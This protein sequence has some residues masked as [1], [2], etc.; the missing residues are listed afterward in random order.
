MHCFICE[1]VHCM[2]IHLA[3]HTYSVGI[4]TMNIQA[5]ALPEYLNEASPFSRI[6]EIIFSIPLEWVHTRDD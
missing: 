6:S 3:N 5:E 2:K 1:F 4:D